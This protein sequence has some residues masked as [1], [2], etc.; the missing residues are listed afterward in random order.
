MSKVSVVFPVSEVDGINIVLNYGVFLNLYPITWQER[1][2]DN[3]WCVEKN[4]MNFAYRV[5]L[6]LCPI[7]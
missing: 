6:N 1:L 3:T 4:K 7:G 5:F 2:A